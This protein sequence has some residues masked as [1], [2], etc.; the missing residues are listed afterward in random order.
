M[1]WG[2]EVSEAKRLRAL[3]AENTKLKRL[4]GDAMLDNIEGKESVKTP[5]WASLMTLLSD[6]AY[7]SFIGEVEALDTTTICPP[8]PV[9]PSPTSGHSSLQDSDDCTATLHLS[10]PLRSGL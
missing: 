5:G 10:V 9:S 1:L 8:Y 2:L 6:T 4:L 7:S 3:E